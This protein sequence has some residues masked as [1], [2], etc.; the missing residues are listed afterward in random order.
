MQDFLLSGATSFLRFVLL[1]ANQQH[2][3]DTSGAIYCAP[4]GWGTAENSAINRAATDPCCHLKGCNDN[5]SQLVS[6]HFSSFD[7]L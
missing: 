4:F 1:V 6:L 2:F 7:I 5:Y 3:Q